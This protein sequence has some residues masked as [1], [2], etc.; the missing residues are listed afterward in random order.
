MRNK[1]TPATNGEGFPTGEVN[2]MRLAPHLWPD[3]GL[4]CILAIKG[5]RR[6]QFFYGP[7]DEDTLWRTAQRLD[8][9]GHD[10]FFAPATFREKGSR[11]ADNAHMVRAFWI[12]LD[13][14]EGKP[15]ADARE[16]AKALADWLKA[17]SFHPP[18]DIVMSGYGLHVYWRLTA[19]ALPEIWRPVAQ[20]FKHALAATGLKVDQSR[21]GDAASVLRLPGLHNHKHG[22]KAAVKLVREGGPAVSLDDFAAALP[23]V[24]PRPLPGK[25]DSE[26]GVETEF[27]PADASLIVSKCAQVAYV[28]G[29][30]GAVEEPLW[31]AA[32]SIAQ[33][34]EGR[35]GVIEAWSRGDSRY[36]PAEALRKAELTGGPATCQHFEGLVPERCQGC[37]WRGKITSPIV[38]GTAAPEPAPH[39]ED[40]EEDLDSRINETRRYRVT[41]KGVFKKANEDADETAITVCPV[42]V[43]EVREKVKRGDER[44][45]TVLKLQWHALDG[46]RHEALVTQAEVFEKREL[47]RWAADNNLASQVND[48]KWTE[49][50]M[51]ISEM[52]RE[53]IRQGKTQTYYDSLGWYGDVFVT[54]K[55]EI[56]KDG[57]H[58]A[59]VPAGSTLSLMESRGDLEAWKAAVA[60]LDDSEFVVHQFL[61]LAGFGSPLLEKVG[62]TS[63]LVSA[64]GPTSSG[65]SIGCSLA[66][67]IYLDP[68][69]ATQTGQAVTDNAIEVQMGL[70]RNV[71]YLL[72]E[73]SHMKGERLGSLVYIAP[74][75][76]GKSV[77]ERSRQARPMHTWSMVPMLTTNSPLRDFSHAVITEA[78]RV[79]LLELTMKGPFP[80]KLGEHLAETMAAN[81]GV[82]AVPYMQ[83]VI[84]ALPRLPALFKEAEAIILREAEF[85]DKFRFSLWTLTAALVGGMLAKK[86]GLIPFDVKAV[87]LE[88]ARRTFH[89]ALTVQRDEE[90]IVDALAEFTTDNYASTC[91]WA[92][93]GRGRRG[94][95]LADIPMR[96]T[97]CRYDETNDHLYIPVNILTDYLREWD[98]SLSNLNDWMGDH[99]IFRKQQK[100]VPG[101]SPV[102][103]FVI[104]ARQ[105]GLEMSKADTEPAQ[106]ED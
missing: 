74:N 31:R 92:V 48:G 86:A 35:E 21:T 25:Q 61:L 100:I 93:G 53:L 14:G 24:G 75:G 49:L 94:A 23:L 68:R 34:C 22:R 62:R 97:T 64:A 103:C 57:P 13:C 66:L 88:I 72:D 46:Q 89:D 96:E 38:L 71:P 10:V 15:Y 83:L 102:W 50:S 91:W 6:K 11:K 44:G 41:A 82:A 3:Q 29:E 45:G 47:V 12:D 104:P 2:Q 58:P 20:R 16:G 9:D 19:P 60:M 28:A 70:L 8:A 101:T 55:Q 37:K 63:A 85:P 77:V 105:T 18:S 106:P 4:R 56:R 33:R 84:K 27:P 78:H 39:E 95:D 98:L 1:E 7:D 67:S 40:T 59:N 5:D 65:K 42:W 54:G 69:Y 36:E 99:G 87:V 26:F 32:L 30:G 43:R 81:H 52:T 17:Q 79:R 51:Y 80:K 90:R 76:R 73:A